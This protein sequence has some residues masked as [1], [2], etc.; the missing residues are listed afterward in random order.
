MLNNDDD[1]KKGTVA[2]VT[3]QQYGKLK[4]Q[5]RYN[6]MMDELMKCNLNEI[7]GD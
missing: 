2:Y 5:L 6:E 3:N 4:S 7:H 1:E